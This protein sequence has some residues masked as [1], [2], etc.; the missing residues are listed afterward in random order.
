VRGDA[1]DNEQLETIGV[2]DRIHT[3]VCATSDAVKNVV[4]TVSSRR[5]NDGLRI[6]ASAGSRY[7]RAVECPVRSSSGLQAVGWLTPECR[8]RAGRRSGRVGNSAPDDAQ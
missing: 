8:C 2:R 4:I 6:I 5:M 3:L 7:R 1:A